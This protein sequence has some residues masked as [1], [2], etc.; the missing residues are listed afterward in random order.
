V[1]STPRPDTVVL[2]K[3]RQPGIVAIEIAVSQPKCIPILVNFY[4][5]FSLWS[6]PLS[7]FLPTTLLWPRISP[8][9]EGL[10]RSL[11]SNRPVLRGEVLELTGIDSLPGNLQ[12][13]PQWLSPEQF[14]NWTDSESNGAGPCCHDRHRAGY[15][16]GLLLLSA[17]GSRRLSSWESC[18]RSR[19]QH[20]RG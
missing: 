12:Y 7:S 16:L 15:R 19:R 20:R 17:R 9:G 5:L 1:S 2:R 6:C 13:D 11:G 4:R 10:A 3:I 8:S 14:L 18:V